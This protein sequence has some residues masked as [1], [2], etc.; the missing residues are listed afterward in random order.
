[1]L[2]AAPNSNPALRWFLVPLLPKP[3]VH[4]QAQTCAVAH[5]HVAS[6]VGDF[7]NVEF[8]SD[9]L[10]RCRASAADKSDTL[11]PLLFGV[12]HAC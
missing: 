1:M 11:P 8:A 6:H 3:L 7:C 4:E 9:H 12:R 10:R 5:D 2:T